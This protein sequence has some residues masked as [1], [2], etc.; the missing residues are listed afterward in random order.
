VDK[1]KQEKTGGAEKS[2]T[3]VTAHQL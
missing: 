1:D 2:D 3:A